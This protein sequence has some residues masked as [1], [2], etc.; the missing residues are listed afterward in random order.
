MPPRK[1]SGK[2][3]VIERVFDQLWDPI[4]KT[5]ARTVVTSADLVEA[6]AWCKEHHGIT[7]SAKNPANFFKDIIR[8]S[9]AEGMWPQKLKDLRW[10][11]RQRTGDGDVLEFVPYK[12]GQNEA[13]PDLFA[14]RPDIP[15]RQIQSLS[16]PLASKELGRD[17]ETYLIQVAVKLAVVE[18]HFA[19]ESPLD[20]A[21]LNHLQMGIKLRK[22][23]IDSLFSAQFTDEDKVKKRLI[24]TAE[25]KNKHQRILPE[26]IIS[27]VRAAFTVAPS[28]EAVAPVAMV[29]RAGGIYFVE[30]KIVR[31]SELAGFEELVLEREAFYELVPHVKGI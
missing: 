29:A 26:Q 11:A 9:G 27:Q 22:T 23:E 28:V 7:L 16:M 18:T 21:E 24:I 3:P 6:I 1:L 10:S 13:F 31:R 25:A 15:H 14:Y 4:S 17:D 20:V 2:P 5:L 8:G 19:L 12:H 30:F